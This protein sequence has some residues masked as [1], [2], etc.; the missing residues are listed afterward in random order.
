MPAPTS[1]TARGGTDTLIGMGGNDVYYTDVAATQVI[2]SAGGGTDAL[3]TSVSYTLAAGADVE[4]L[5]TNNSAG[6]RRDQ[7]DRQRHRQHHLRQCRQ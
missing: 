7:P 5:S 6:S 1:C 4:I 2:E 3:Y